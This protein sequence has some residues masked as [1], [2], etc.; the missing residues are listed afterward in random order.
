MTGLPKGWTK[1]DI[2]QLVELQAN[3]KPFQQGWSPQCESRP[4]TDEEWGVV[5]TTA[6]QHGEFWAHEN[7]ALPTKLEPKPAIEILAGDVLMTCA[8]PRN[9]CGVACLVT[10]TRSKLMMSGKM[11]RFRPHPAIL[12]AHYLSFFLREHSTQ[13]RINEMKTGISDSGLNL[14]H[15]RFAKLPLAVPP[16]NE[17]RRIVDKIEAAFAEIDAGVESLKAARVKLGLYRQSLLKSAFEGRLTADWRAQ[18]A[19]KLED[20]KTLLARIQSERDTR[21]KT[22]LDD[23]QTAL[24][25]WREDGE[26]GKKPA[27]PKR[28]TDVASL[29]DKEMEAIPTTPTEWGLSRLGLYIDRIEAGKSF[30]CLETEPQG[31]QVGV[32]K[33]SAVSWGEYNEAESKTCLDDSK[34]NADWFIQEGDFLLSRANTIELVGAS[35]IV[36]RTT[37]Q[38]MLSDKTLRVHF[39]PK[40]RRFFLYYLRS[41]YGRNEIEN[42][43][44]GNQES[45]R[46]IG[47]DRIKSIVMPICSAAEQTEIVLILDA[48]LQAAD[49]MEAEIDAALTRAEALRQS[50]LKKAFSG[51]LVPQDPTDEPASTLLDR[52]QAERAAKKVKPKAK[53]KTSV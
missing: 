45:M 39:S 14:T 30:K 19:D 5:K 26:N 33:V 18:N 48:K 51:K 37:K 8:G 42:R 49:A 31:D 3:G 6:I 16:L 47:Q 20:P 13:L 52:I 53:R 15:G 4:A 23:W 10:S 28:P 50:I 27:K 25:Q 46:N 7:K 44:T 12:N 2:E 41:P 38:I 32:A 9:R 24:E 17:Q 11:Y 34:V 29:D 1:A 36:K 21:Y 43:S 35:V 22:A 40:D